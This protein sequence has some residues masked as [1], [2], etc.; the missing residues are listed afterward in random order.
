M[1]VYE[2]LNLSA[3]TISNLH[4]KIVTGSDISQYKLM[5]MEEAPL[6]NRQKHLELLCFPSLFPTD[7]M[8]S[9]AI[10]AIINHNETVSSWP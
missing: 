8:E 7:N 10:I 6:D 4:S 9:S 2:D 3:Y 5:N 1:L